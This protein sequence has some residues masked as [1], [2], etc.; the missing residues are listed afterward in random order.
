M[1]NRVG[2]A[3]YS[4]QAS[5]GNSSSTLDAQLA[6]FESQLA[7]WESCPSCKTP[8]GKAKIADIVEKISDIRRRIESAELA[9]QDATRSRDS[10][11]NEASRSLTDPPDPGGVAST[12]AGV[13]S[14]LSV[15][16]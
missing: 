14:L 8:E 3:F 13:G 6:K 15:Y 10:G 9:K 2:G 1:L 7:S 16:A 11:G 12:T 5:Q 4:A